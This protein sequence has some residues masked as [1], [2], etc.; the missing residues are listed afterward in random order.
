[1]VDVPV[2]GTG[3]Y[4]VSVRVRPKA[5]IK[6]LLSSFF[7][8][9]CQNECFMSPLNK[10]SFFSSFLWKRCRKDEKNVFHATF[11]KKKTKR[12]EMTVSK[13]DAIYSFGI[14]KKICIT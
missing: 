6:T 12:N 11:D 13:L 7:S 2:L 8:K 5:K 3:V 9:R 1:M 4:D 10:S 14:L